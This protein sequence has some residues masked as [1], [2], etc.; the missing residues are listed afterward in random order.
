MART[1]ARFCQRDGRSQRRRN[2]LIPAT[3]GADERTLLLLLAA[4]LVA[5]MSG[6]AGAQPSPTATPTSCVGDCNGDGA[7]AVNEL[8]MGVGIE[9]GSMS[10]DAC[11]AYA[12]ACGPAD[13]PSSCLAV[14]HPA[15]DTLVRAVNNAMGGCPDPGEAGDLQWV[16]ACGP[17]VVRVDGEPCPDS[18]KRCT[19]EQLGE[20]CSERW[21]TCCEADSDCT[22]DICNAGLLC[23]TEP[24]WTCPISRRRYKQ[25]IEYL[26]PVALAQLHDALLAIKLATFRYKREAP[27][28]APHLGFII[29]DIEPSPS[30]D[31]AHD[32]VDL[33]GYLSMAVGAIQ[34]QAKQ[35]EA[36]QQEIRG[37][38]QELQRADTEGPPLSCSR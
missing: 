38:R 36:L 20:P 9:L 5:V 35:I 1:H 3:S 13:D 12:Q 21:A 31:S 4:G 6:R 32:M 24:P 28:A 16:T 27:A 26:G 2:G 14:Q 37:L 34:V 33:Y 17:P 11:V 19:S 8:V 25:D 15:V 30:V 18:V 10:A 29:E 22:G 23:N 7:V